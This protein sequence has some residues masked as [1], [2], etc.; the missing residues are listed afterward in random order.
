[1]VSAHG[2]DVLNGILFV[3]V[4]EN[5]KARLVTESNVIAFARGVSEPEI[6]GGFDREVVTADATGRRKGNVVI[7]NTTD[8]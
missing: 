4:D 8:L 2:N 7:V 3:V 6:D 5:E 1:M